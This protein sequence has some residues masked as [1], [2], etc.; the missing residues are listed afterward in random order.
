MDCDRSIELLSDYTA[1]SLGDNDKIFISTHLLD[2]VNCKGVFED[3]RLIVQTATLLRAENNGLAYPD[4]ELLWARV[5]VG[6][7][8]H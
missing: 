1:D 6:R 2:C 3:L 4:E 7:V 5:S 8:V